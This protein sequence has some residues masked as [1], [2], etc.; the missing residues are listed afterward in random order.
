MTATN[1]Q[2]TSD[3]QPARIL[4]TPRTDITQLI[5]QL[6]YAWGLSMAEPLAQYVAWSEE[7]GIFDLL[8]SRGTATIHDICAATPLSFAGADALLG[9]LGSLTLVERDSNSLYSLT[10]LAR[11][12]IL[13]ASPYWVGAGLYVNCGREIPHTYLRKYDD[14]P[15]TLPVI[16][17]L[18]EPLR[19]GIQHSRNFAPSVVAARTGAFAGIRHLIDVAGGSGVFSIPLALDSPDLRITLVELPSILAEVGKILRTYG[20]DQ[21][22]QLLGLDIFRE[23]WKFPPGDAILVANIVHAYDDD[24]ANYIC[25]QAFRALPAG[26]KLLLHEVLF[27]EERTG[28]LMAAVWN[29]NMRARSSGAR[30]R[31]GC[32]LL[33]LLRQH[34]FTDAKIIPTAGCFS[35]ITGI[36]N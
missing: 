34:G 6:R 17:G 35:L 30:Q 32:E 24:T 7:F 15:A 20:V 8:E 9:V 12:Y 1:H 21:R 31:S 26:G 28:P 5:D 25:E 4:P 16:Q 23:E 13:K 10:L 29:A 14:V 18:P 22:V 2:L 19:L 27:N 33:E 3:P 11:E 36:K